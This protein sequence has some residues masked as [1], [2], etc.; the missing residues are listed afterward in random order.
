MYTC[1]SENRN[2]AVEDGEGLQ[3]AFCDYL[4]VAG[5]RTGAWDYN[6]GRS[7]GTPK[8]PCDGILGYRTKVRITDVTDGTSN[9]FLVGERPPSSDFVF[10]WWFA[11]AGFD[12]SGR[13]DVTLGPREYSYAA[14]T[15]GLTGGTCLPAD[16]GFHTGNVNDP[17]AQV[18]FW[19][20]HTGGANFLRADASVRFTPYSIDTDPTQTTIG[21]TF[22][23]MCTRNKG[24]V[25]TDY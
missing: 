15:T 22:T 20:F 25:V 7:R 6:I 9:T 2:L 17:C 19:S 12:A 10:G 1:P 23:Y 24:E 11:G 3:V 18:R 8:E 16:V 21:S 4:G 13:G 14:S 5:F